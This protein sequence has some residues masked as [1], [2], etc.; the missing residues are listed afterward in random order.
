VSGLF[1]DG[2]ELKDGE[3]SANLQVLEPAVSRVSPEQGVSLSAIY[4]PMVRAGNEKIMAMFF[5]IWL[6]SGTKL[7]SLKNDIYK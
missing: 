5:T 3:G 1:R 2:H 6:S 4:Q 7:N